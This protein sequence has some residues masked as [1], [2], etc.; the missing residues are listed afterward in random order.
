MSLF[1]LGNL[2]GGAAPTYEVLLAGRIVTGVA[3]GVVF[4]VG[5]PIAMS[6]AD[7]ER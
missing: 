3:H 2:L 6:L 4:A 5:A 1:T 7:R